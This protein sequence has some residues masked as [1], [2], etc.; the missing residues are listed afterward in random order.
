MVEP[1]NP[2]LNPCELTLDPRTGFKAAG[3]RRLAEP[4]MPGLLPERTWQQK[5]S[6]AEAWYG[7]LR[8]HAAQRQSDAM[9]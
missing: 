3:E 2:T 1:L 5:Y 7:Q 6:R 4:C 9:S 8:Q